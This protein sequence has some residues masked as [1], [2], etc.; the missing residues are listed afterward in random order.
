MP[1][2]AGGTSPAPEAGASKGDVSGPQ[3][4]ALGHTLQVHPTGTTC[5]HP[6]HT[7]SLGS[8]SPASGEVWGFASSSTMTH[9]FYRWQGPCQSGAP[10]VSG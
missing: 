1:L 6:H 9:S 3:A 7:T 2:E 8:H 5:E 4:L 10:A